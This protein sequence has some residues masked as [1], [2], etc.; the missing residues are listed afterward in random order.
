V[1][2]AAGYDQRDGALNKIFNHLDHH[3]RVG[4]HF[5]FL[6]IVGPGPTVAPTN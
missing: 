5:W 4:V 2:R 3:R 1:R 6:I